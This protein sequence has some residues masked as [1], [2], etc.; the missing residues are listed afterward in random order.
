MNAKEALSIIRGVEDDEGL[1]RLDN[2]VREPRYQLAK[3]YLKALEGEEVRILVEALE[4]ISFG[5]KLSDLDNYAIMA[6]R[7]VGIANCALLKFKKLQQAS[8][9]Q[10]GEGCLTV[11]EN[12]NKGESE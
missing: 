1:L 2:L 7:L 12:R 5:K 10:T 3:V 9:Q 11:V 8:Q 4:E 6:C